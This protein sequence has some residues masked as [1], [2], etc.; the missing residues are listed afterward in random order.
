LEPRRP[1]LRRLGLGRHERP[2][3]LVIG[4][5]AGCAA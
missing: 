2:P 4:E 5:A 3:S 1:S